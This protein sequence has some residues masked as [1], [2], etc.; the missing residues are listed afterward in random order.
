MDR[1]KLIPIMAFCLYFG[2]LFFQPPTLTDAS[3][4]LI[5]SATAAYFQY[6]NSEKEI[7]D[8]NAKHAEIERDLKKKSEDID[9]LKST[10][11]SMRLGNSLRPTGNQ[12]R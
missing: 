7:K 3:I 10:V 5:L 1:L 4:L 12:T 6:K 8:L 2:R 11:A 9:F